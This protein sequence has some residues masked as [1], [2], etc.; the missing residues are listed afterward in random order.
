MI[1]VTYDEHGGF[2]DHVAPPAAEDDFPDCRRHGPRVPAFVI[3]PWVAERQVEHTAF[4]HASIV[5]T[6]LARFCR[7]P[8]DGTVPDMGARVRAASHLGTVLRRTSARPS[9][10]RSQYQDVIDETRAWQEALAAQSVIATDQGA[11]SPQAEL[12]DF[13]Q[14]FV[15]YRK[16]VLDARAARGIRPPAPN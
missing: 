12:T 13:Q 5:K 2:Y 9:I 14:E 4:D 1:V 11:V 6:V 8:T 3:S 15:A 7:N 16:A 10:A